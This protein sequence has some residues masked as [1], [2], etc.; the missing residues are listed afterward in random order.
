MPHVLWQLQGMQQ[1]VWEGEVDAQGN[2][3]KHFKEFE[4]AVPG[5]L[6]SEEYD[7]FVRDTVNFLD[8][9]GEP[10]QREAAVARLPS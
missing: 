5:K 3:Q 6:S 1:A 4:L 7:A 10:V 8:Y 9:I 2:A